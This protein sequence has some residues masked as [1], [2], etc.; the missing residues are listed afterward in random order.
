MNLVRLF[1]LLDTL[2]YPKCSICKEGNSRCFEAKCQCSLNEKRGYSL[3]ELVTYP[4]LENRSSKQHIRI[5]S[6]S[7]LHF[8]YIEKWGSRGLVLH[9]APE[10]AMEE[11]SMQMITGRAWNV[12]WTL[13]NV[14]MD[15][16][17]ANW[18]SLWWR[19]SS[20]KRARKLL[21][22]CRVLQWLK[23]GIQRLMDQ[24]GRLTF[25]DSWLTDDNPLDG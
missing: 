12:L 18:S 21:R 8:L 4:F 20:K 17:V 1:G 14:S 13:K 16:L 23:S 19:R 15:S 10:P 9:Q 24:F 22:R 5:N 2:C 25:V 7:R 6:S 11:S 3:E